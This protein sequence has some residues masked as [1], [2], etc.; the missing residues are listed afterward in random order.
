[1]AFLG[2]R[3]TGPNLKNACSLL[4]GSFFYSMQL[5]ILKLNIPRFLYGAVSIKA[6]PHCILKPVS[7][8]S[9]T[10]S[11]PGFIPMGSIQFHLKPSEG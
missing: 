8:V 4:L 7:P 10:G 3:E 2:I 5:D 1:M 6:C 9:G 11:T